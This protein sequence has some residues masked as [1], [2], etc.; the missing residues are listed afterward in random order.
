[1]SESINQVMLNFLDRMI[2]ENVR[3]AE[4]LASLRSIIAE[5]RAEQKESLGDLQEKIE[6]IQHQFSNGFKAEIKD[7]VSSEMEHTQ[8]FINELKKLMETEEEK[9]KRLAYYEKFDKFIDKIS[10]PRFWAALFVSLVVGIST[11][12]GAL[13]TAWKAIDPLIN[14][15]PDAIV[16]PHKP[17]SVPAPTNPPMN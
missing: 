13:A 12:M 5:H 7:H 16:Q 2:D 17:S 3:S 4:A 10:S 1:M 15:K 8:D 9:K 14:K 6:K 11:I